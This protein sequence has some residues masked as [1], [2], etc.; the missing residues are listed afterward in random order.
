MNKVFIS[1]RLPNIA[2]ELLSEEFKV[3]Y[4]NENKPL[5]KKKLYDLVE[6][7]DAILSTVSDKFTKDILQCKGKLKVISN[8][9]TGIDNIDKNFAEIKGISVYN[10]PDI[11]T[12]S[13]ADLTVSIF[14]A[15]IRK[16]I[17]AQKFVIENK[18]KHWD[19][20]IFLGEELHGKK[21]GI[22]GFGKVGSAVAKRAKGFG[23]E[24]IFNN[25]SR[26]ENSGDPS[27]RQVELDE[28]FHESDYLS[29]HLPL[30]NET[31]GLINYEIFSKM[32]KKP[33]IINMA[34]GEILVTQA[35]IQ[36]L[37]E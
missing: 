6:N 5:E 23:L 35:L 25:R 12:N 31:E 9:G 26:I 20:E 8:Y 32:R 1:R 3:S 30:N 36:A 28:L 33:V 24:I 29:I 34:R 4:N 10:T 21:F 2:R 14:L 11:V 17:P 18:W 16:I 15:L 37:S 7:Y 27:F 19:P 13:T 22:W